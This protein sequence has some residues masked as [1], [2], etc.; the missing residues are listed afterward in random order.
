MHRRA[1][2]VAALCDRFM[3][4]HVGH[5]CK[6]STQAEYR[7]SVE[8]FIKPRIGNLKLLDVKRADIA[9]LHQDLRHIPYQANRTLGVLKRMFSPAEAWGLVPDGAN[10][11][12][13]VKPYPETE[14]GRFLSAEE[15]EHSGQRSPSSRW[16]SQACD[17]RSTRSASSR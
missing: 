7:R 2:T 12:R 3:S 6:P 9:Q 5:H 15:Y 1:P 16:S 13:H 11:C 4:E 14:R 8:I 10:P 17:R